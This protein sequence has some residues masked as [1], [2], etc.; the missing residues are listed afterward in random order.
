MSEAATTAVLTATSTPVAKRLVAPLLFAAAAVAVP[1]LHAQGAIQ[2][3]TVNM[4]G[5]YLCFAIVAIGLDLIWGYTGILSLCQSFFFAL[6]GYAMGMHLALQGTLTNGIPESLYVVYPYAIGEAKGAEILPWYWQPFHHLAPALLL[7]VAIPAG[8]A[9]LTGFFGF[10]SRVRGVYFSILTQAL[11][12][13]AA[14][15]FGKN[16]MKLCGTN[17]LTHFKTLAGFDLTEPS[18]K[19]GLYVLSV[20]GLAAAYFGCRYLVN[21]RLGR[22][23]VAIRD[24]EGTLRFSGY[25]PHQFKVFVFAVA[26]G[27]AGLAGLLYVPQAMIINPSTMEARWSILVVIWV[28]VGGRGTLGGAVLGALVVNLLYNALTSERDLGLIHWKPAYWPFLLGVL[29]VAMVLKFPQGLLPAAKRL[30]AGRK[31]AA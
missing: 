17:G 7:A 27:L 6:G 24:A 12:V 5:R 2:T 13:A 16:E 26:A 4:L 20:A 23:L 1:L 10:K 28:A 25:Q 3:E 15:F 31:A 18:V 14:M 21:S 9:A 19:V 30:F 29:F 8:F 22:V 11:T